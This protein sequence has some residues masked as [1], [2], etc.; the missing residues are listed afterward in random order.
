MCSEWKMWV[1]LAHD[2][3][4][5]ASSLNLIHIPPLIWKWWH[6]Q[7]TNQEQELPSSSTLNTQT[8]HLLEEEGLGGGFHALS[9]HLEDSQAT[10]WNCVNTMLAPCLFRESKI[11]CHWHRLLGW[12]CR[13]GLQLWYRSSKVH[14]ATNKKGVARLDYDSQITRRYGRW[15]PSGAWPTTE[16]LLN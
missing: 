10:I 6:C 16:P 1:I 15:R 9:A 2:L 7:L 3:S 12:S 14:F 13:Q 4:A 8:T 5:V 11:V